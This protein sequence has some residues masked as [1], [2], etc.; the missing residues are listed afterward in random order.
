MM[1]PVVKNVLIINVLVF[2]AMYGLSLGAALTPLGAWMQEWLALWP[3]GTPE[4]A[5]SGQGLVPVPRFWPWQLVTSAF[6][7]GGFLHLLF[8]MLVLWMF[9]MR[10]ENVWG[11]QRF[12][13]F[14]FWCAIGGSLLQLLFSSAP[15]LFG[16]GQPILTA[17]LGAS[18][19]VLGVLVA[20][21]M[22]YP[23]ERI[24]FYFVIP[25]K[26]MYLVIG[27]A[28]LSVVAGV[29]GAM[30]GIA[31]WAHLGGMIAGYLLI[32]YWR[33]RLPFG[34]GRRREYARRD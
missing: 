33:G 13:I 34:P 5:R 4:L 28:V 2:F 11:S 1:P 15:F 9:G 17:T 31:H 29:T 12:G 19:A 21:A 18:G 25:I 22:M 26:A 20:F 30:P 24:Y 14:Y 3:A 8:N 27:T 23:D 16:I 10:V 7:H 32:Q 6:M